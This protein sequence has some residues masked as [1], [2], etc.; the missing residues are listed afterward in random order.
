MED[1][2]VNKST[3]FIC[4]EVFAKVGKFFVKMN[5]YGSEFLFFLPLV[6][7]LSLPVIEQLPN[8]Y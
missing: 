7:F 3:F 6:F 5:F 1:Y 2:Y 8:K 4:H